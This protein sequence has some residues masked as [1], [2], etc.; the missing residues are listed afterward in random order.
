[1]CVHPHRSG[2]EL[3]EYLLNVDSTHQEEKKLYATLFDLL[4][5]EKI[6]FSG[7]YSIIIPTPVVVIIQ[8]IHKFTLCALSTN[9]G[10]VHY[11]LIGTFLEVM[12][13]KS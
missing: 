5:F 7:T 3:M 6:A 11:H 4:S 9:H 13:R 12:R 8:F 1:V 2:G 10:A